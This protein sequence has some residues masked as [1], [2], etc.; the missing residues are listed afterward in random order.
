MTDNVKFDLDYSD[1]PFTEED[2]FESLL[3]AGIIDTDGKV[4]EGGDE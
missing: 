3:E 2:L 1:L 4:R